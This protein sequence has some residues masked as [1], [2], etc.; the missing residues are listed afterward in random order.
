MTLRS[1]EVYFSEQDSSFIIPESVSLFG[2]SIS[3]Y[4][5]CLLLAALVG[6]V[7]VTEAAKRK[8]Q[9]AEKVLTLLTLV[10]VSALVG[11]RLYYILFDWQNFVR[12]PLAVFQFRSGGLSYYG[13][14]FGAWFAV[15]MFCRKTK[16]DFSEYADTLS[17]GAASAA[18]LIWTGCAFVREPLGRFY[19]GLFS[20]R[21]EATYLSRE[22]QAAYSDELMSNVWNAENSV[23]YIRMH[24][25]AIY[26]IVLSAVLFFV[27]CICAVKRKADGEVFT[28]YLMLNAVLIAGLELLRADSACIWG[29]EIPVNYV[30]SGVIAATIVN[31]KVR[32]LL[33]KRKGKKKL[34]LA[35]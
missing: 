22:M 18:P 6:I 34:F 9:D 1:G 14:V 24:P 31:G 13:G 11:A 23:A 21:I 27:L 2:L 5:L 17:M 35:Q 30:V 19:D 7:L 8:R 29:T 12:N 28:A 26:G 32:R 16:T 15:K 10:I 20:V 25:V 3:F 33:K 4:G